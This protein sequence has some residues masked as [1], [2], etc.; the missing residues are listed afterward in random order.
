MLLEAMVWV[1]ML[2]HLVISVFTLPLRS[3][4]EHHWGRRIALQPA[5]TKV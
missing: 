5:K 4:Y 1:S 3:Y 2:L